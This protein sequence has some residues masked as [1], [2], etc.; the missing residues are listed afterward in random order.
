MTHAALAPVAECIAVAPAV[1]ATQLVSQEQSKRCTVE[2]VVDAAP[3]CVIERADAS[4]CL[5]RHA[6]GDPR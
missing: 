4:R 1:E 3:A 2:Q 5:R 6:D